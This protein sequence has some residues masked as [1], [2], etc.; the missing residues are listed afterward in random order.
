MK[1]LEAFSCKPAMIPTATLRR[2]ARVLASRWRH[3]ILGDRLL[4]LDTRDRAGILDLADRVCQVHATGK[5]DV[6][7]AGTKLPSINMLATV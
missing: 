1:K 4:L 3:K 5:G 7:L 2:D 6:L